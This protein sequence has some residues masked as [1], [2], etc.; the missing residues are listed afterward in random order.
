MNAPR[1]V[2]QRG[3][4]CVDMAGCLG[5][6]EEHPPEERIVAGCCDARRLILGEPVELEGGEEHDGFVC[7]LG[8]TREGQNVPPGSDGAAVAPELSGT[9]GPGRRMS[10]VSGQ[11][12]RLFLCQLTAVRTELVWD[13]AQR[14]E[15]ELRAEVLCALARIHETEESSEIVRAERQLG[16]HGRERIRDCGRCLE[17]D[18][19]LFSLPFRF[20]GLLLLLA[21]SL[22]R[23]EH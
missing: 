14:G 20:H 3:M 18:E 16:E 5:V 1:D 11:P 10:G 9:S 8:Q 15:R 19:R 13:G 23:Q 17:R 7:V 2:E 4:H 21:T 6:T 12:H 22:Q